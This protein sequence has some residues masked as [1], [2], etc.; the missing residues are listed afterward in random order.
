MTEKELAKMMKEALLAT[1]ELHE[2]KIRMIDLRKINEEILSNKDIDHDTEVAAQSAL[3]T[4]QELFDGMEPYM[5]ER[6]KIDEAT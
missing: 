6:H 5:T 3:F 4:L 1:Q 2:V